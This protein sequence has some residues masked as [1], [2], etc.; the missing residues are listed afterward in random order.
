MK[1]FDVIELRVLLCG[2]NGGYY[3]LHTEEGERA[4][5]LMK[6]GVFNSNPPENWSH[7]GYA[8]F[9]KKGR[10]YFVRFMKAVRAKHGHDWMTNADR[11]EDYIG[12]EYGSQ[13]DGFAYSSGYHN[14]Y[15]CKKCGFSFCIHCLTEL[16]IPVCNNK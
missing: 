15:V 2:D 11:D 13:L 1:R 10:A 8:G 7:N 14:G 4:L 6:E 5:I 16:E 9:T 12:T 3:P